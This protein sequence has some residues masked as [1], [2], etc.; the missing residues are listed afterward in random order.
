[1]GKKARAA[2]M[3]DLATSASSSTLLLA[4]GSLL[5]EGFDCPHLDTLFLA[6]PIKFR[7]RVE[8]YVGRVMR[9]SPGKWS[10]EIHDYFDSLFPQVRG[11]Y[12]ERLDAYDRLGI[13]LP[14]DGRP[15]RR[16]RSSP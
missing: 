11:I 6:F 10:V 5:G 13:E 2:V 3:A 8:Q 14:P 4:T 9:A 15:R 7:G 16:R 1:M 12:H